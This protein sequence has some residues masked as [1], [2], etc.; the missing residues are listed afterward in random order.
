MSSGKTNSGVS[1]AD[2][3][4]IV[5]PYAAH[6]GH[7]WNNAERLAVALQ[8][9]G[10]SIRVLIHDKTIRPP[11]EEI[12][13]LINVA[14]RWWQRLVGMILSIVEYFHLP[15][16]LCHPLETFGTLVGLSHMLRK[17][18]SIRVVHV[19]DATFLVFFL[20]QFFTKRPCVYNLTGDAGPLKLTRF[21]SDPLRWLKR[22][23]TQKLLALCLH[24]GCLEFCA[25]T[26]AVRVDW[27]KIVGSHVHFVPYAISPISRPISREYARKSVD[28]SQEPTVVLLFG[29]QRP[30]K[31]FATVIRASGRLSPPPLLL[32]VGKYIAG[33]MPLA[34]LSDLNFT[35]YCSVDRFVNESEADLY[36]AA[37]DAVLLPYVEGY[38]K[39][40]GVLLEACRHLKPVIATDTGYLREFVQQHR[41]GML[42]RAGDAEDLARCIQ[43]IATLTDRERI[44]LHNEMVATVERYSWSR[45][46]ED[47]LA[48]YM[49]LSNRCMHRNNKQRFT[50]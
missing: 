26:E 11:A 17:D 46:V 41:T 16:S 13:A 40:S 22:S 44:T 37:C 5:S 24:N 49:L 27:A 15:G 28:L 30:D 32:F 47:Y 10:Q 12:A 45:I 43:K 29:T 48:L 33:P 38:E 1:T 3:V 21:L 6:P 39:G 42:F 31:D 9:H 8:K 35:S 4:V 23:L 20:W 18:S 34:I 2:V 50:A 36:F 7:H 25:E 19:I 14:P